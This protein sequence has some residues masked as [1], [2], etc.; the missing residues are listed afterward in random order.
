MPGP[1][2][3]VPVNLL[4]LEKNRLCT[5]SY[6]KIKSCIILIHYIYIVESIT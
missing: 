5:D 2:T 4:Q 1:F 3:N 6:P